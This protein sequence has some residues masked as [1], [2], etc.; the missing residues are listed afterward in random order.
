MKFVLVNDRAAR[1]AWAQAAVPLVEAVMLQ[2]TPLRVLH[3]R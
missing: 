2:K 3:D 1:F